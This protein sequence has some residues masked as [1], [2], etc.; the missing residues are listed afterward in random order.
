MTRRLAL[1]VFFHPEGLLADHVLYYLQGLQTV[2]SDVVLIANGPLSDKG[3]AHLAAMSVSWLIRDN[4]GLDF[5]AWKEALERIGYEK[6]ADYDELILCNC[7][8][9]GP[10]YPFSE[11]FTRMEGEACDFWGLFRHPAVPGMYPAHLQSYFLVLRRTVTTSQAFRTYWHDLKTARNWEEAVGQEVLFT[12]YFEN[13]GFVSR[14]YMM[15]RA[16]LSYAA[17]LSVLLPQLLARQGRFPLLKRKAF[18]EDYRLFF[19][20]GDVAQAREMFAILAEESAFPVEYIY[21]DLLQTMPASAIRRILHDLFVL[22]D[23]K[24]QTP[25]KPE[26]RVAL[27]LFSTVELLIDDC[28]R[29]LRSVPECTD[30]YVVVT[31]EA[32]QA[33]WE[34]RVATLSGLAVHVRVQPHRGS[35]VSAC[36]LTCRDVLETHDL[37]CF[38]RDVSVARAHPTLQNYAF[39]HHCWS[40]VLHSPAYVRNVLA[41]FRH[42]KHLGLLLVAPPIFA[43]NVWRFLNPE[44]TAVRRWRRRLYK[45]FGLHVPFDETPDIPQ[46]GMFWARSK[47]MASLY[48]HPWCAEAFPDESDKTGLRLL[49]A[50]EGCYTMIAQ[51]AGYFS[52]W[53]MPASTMG[54]HCD[55]MYFWMQQRES[56]LENPTEIHFNDVSDVVKRYFIKKINR[57]KRKLRRTET[58]SWQMAQCVSRM[59]R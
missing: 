21:Q 31:A 15:D 18:T 7:S 16:V 2:A 11:V 57:L 50:L 54:T 5:A 38:A 40:G 43:D 46:G 59:L 32:M 30:V 25:E 9:Y 55:N 10:I 33:A 19:S 42:K 8:C 53:I 51:E 22:S 34:R 13:R 1:Y 14:A 37:F 41:L 49:E 48:R 24:T 20:H 23:G 36:W 39:R 3:K 56:F 47:A 26:E 4:V 35:A 29:Y 12:Q 28:L 6:L 27:I 17:N 45:Q 58:R 44:K 52:A